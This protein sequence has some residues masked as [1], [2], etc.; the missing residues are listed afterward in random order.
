MIG[1]TATVDAEGAD[2]R[3]DEPYWAK[4]GATSDK[5]GLTDS[6]ANF[7]TRIKISI[8]KVWG[9]PTSAEA[10][11]LEVPRSRPDLHIDATHPVGD[12]GDRAAGVLHDAPDH[13]RRRRLRQLAVPR[14]HPR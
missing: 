6:M 3:D 5:F 4:Y 2:P 13:Q 14:P 12:D 8:D 11:L 7:N 9:T 10:S 1:G